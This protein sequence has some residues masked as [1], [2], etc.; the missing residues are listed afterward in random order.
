MC[1]A[2][3]TTVNLMHNDNCYGVEYFAVKVTSMS[4]FGLEK[5][6]INVYLVNIIC[7]VYSL[8]TVRAR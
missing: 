5:Y 3:L 2:L 7:F 6:E 8:F 4:N 1:S